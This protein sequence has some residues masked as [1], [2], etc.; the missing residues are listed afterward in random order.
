MRGVDNRMPAWRWFLL[1]GVTLAVFAIY[2]LIMRSW[3][4][5][6][7]GA[8]VI[9]LVWSLAFIRLGAHWYEQRGRV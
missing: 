8:P 9:A 5:L 1:A 7:T 3:A 2:A 6:Q 4:P